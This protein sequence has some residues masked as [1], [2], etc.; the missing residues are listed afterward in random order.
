MER[1]PGGEA[2]ELDGRGHD[3][4]LASIKGTV[5]DPYNLP[6]GCPFHPRCAKKIAGVCDVEIPPVIEVEPGHK[7]RSLWPGVSSWAPMD[8][9]R[10]K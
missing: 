6:N 1:G 2:P 8:E 7:V 10:I 4:R 5:P 3:Y 9:M